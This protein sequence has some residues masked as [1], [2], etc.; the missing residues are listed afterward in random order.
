MTLGCT[1]TPNVAMEGVALLL[2]FAEVPGSYLG[3]ETSY[4][5]LCV[6]WLS[7]IPSGK[8]IPH[9]KPRLFPST[10]F[11]LKLSLSLT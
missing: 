3:T 8:L 7:V 9:I 11:K 1:K 2:C 6:S 10:R 5:D 4:P